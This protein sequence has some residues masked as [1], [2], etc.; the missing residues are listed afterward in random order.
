MSHLP[1]K[2]ADPQINTEYLMEMYQNLLSEESNIK[3][4]FGYMKNQ[5]DIN[6]K[7]RAMLIDWIIDVHF[8]FKLKSET[9]FLTVW[10]REKE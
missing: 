4:L 7:M 6:E 9:L 3:S 2:A 1:P 8:K 10:C 5:P